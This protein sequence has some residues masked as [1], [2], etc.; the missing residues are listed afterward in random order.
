MMLSFGF[1]EDVETI[2]QARCHNPPVMLECNAR[3]N[4]IPQARCPFF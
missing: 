4:F 1:E 3:Y 2:L